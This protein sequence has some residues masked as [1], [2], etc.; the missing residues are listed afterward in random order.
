MTPFEVEMIAIPKPFSTRGTFV[1][2]QYWRKPGLLMRSN[3]L[4]A[5]VFVSGLYLSAILIF[6]WYPTSSSNL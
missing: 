5:E 2:S 1:E 3:A 4:M 6:P